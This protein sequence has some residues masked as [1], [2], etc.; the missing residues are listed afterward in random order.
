MKRIWGHALS[1]LV[2]GMA[3]SASLPAC[4]KNDQS[5]FIQQ[6]LAPSTNRQNNSCIYTTDPTQPFLTSGFL[7]LGVSD[8]YQA[9]VLIG[10][11]LRPQADPEN[12]RTESARFHI[13]G[14][15]VRVLETNGALIKEFTTFTAGF[16][17]PSSST[18]PNYCVGGLTLI[19][20]D[21]GRLIMAKKPAE[22]DQY[23]FRNQVLVSFK[24]FGKTLGGTEI[25]SDEFVYPIDT[26]FGCSVIFAGGNDA[27][28]TVQPNCNAPLA[29]GGGTSLPCRR[30]QD[31]AT[32]CQLC[33]SRDA[34]D[35]AQR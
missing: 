24:A 35:P 2:A 1:L 7:D 9:N 22:V 33:P 3:V 17:N 21:T 29:A 14:A 20:A 4:A 11:Q 6:V 32:P 27:T 25:E 12:L 16:S 28:S 26:C 23:D 8:D 13:L 19:D 34:C 30:G 10:N 5:I 18:A 15:V 31:E